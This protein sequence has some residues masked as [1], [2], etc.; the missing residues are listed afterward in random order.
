MAR[1]ELVI[2]STQAL[3]QLLRCIT[4]E[5]IPLDDQQAINTGCGKVVFLVLAKHHGQHRAV[6]PG[7][8]MGEAKQVAI[9]AAQAA[10]D[11]VRDHG[12]VKRRLQ[13]LMQRQLHHRCRTALVAGA[14][15][16]A[17]AVDAFDAVGADK[18]DTM[19]V[20]ADEPVGAHPAVLLTL[21]HGRVQRVQA[22]AGDPLGARITANNV[23]HQCTS[24]GSRFAG[25][26][27][28]AG[29]CS[30]SRASATSSARSLINGRGSTT[31]SSI[32]VHCGQPTATSSAAVSRISSMRMSGIRCLPGMS[33]I[34]APPPP[35]Q[36]RERKPERCISRTSIPRALSTARGAS[37]S[38]L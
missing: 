29:A 3:H 21:L 28:L 38:P 35:P 18:A 4:V 32:A 31:P 11:H 26:G 22:V 12:D 10:T 5:F 19:G 16:G 36:Q 27:L 2:H 13:H 24:A 14:L 9:V 15:L 34:G 23:A 6:T 7:Q 8:A 17:T 20:L 37:Y 30:S 33:V 1:G 25:A